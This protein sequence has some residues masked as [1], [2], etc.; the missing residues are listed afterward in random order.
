M[1]GGHEGKVAR[2]R[3]KE[4]GEDVCLAANS[5]AAAFVKESNVVSTPRKERP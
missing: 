2:S 5:Y 3:L 1:S 4:N